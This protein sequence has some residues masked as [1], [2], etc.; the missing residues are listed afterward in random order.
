MSSTSGV[1]SH[2]KCMKW[3]YWHKTETCT[4]KNQLSPAILLLELAKR[5]R[6]II[7][8][9]YTLKSSGLRSSQI[10]VPQWALE[11]LPAQAADKTLLNYRLWRPLLFKPCKTKHIIRQGTQ[12]TV[13]L[14]LALIVLQSRQLTC[15]KMT[16]SASKGILVF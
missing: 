11:S 7:Q 9:F 12:S 16:L 5:I 10:G 14:W 6:N 2:H 15:Q 8:M 13:L 1:V 3:N 4:H